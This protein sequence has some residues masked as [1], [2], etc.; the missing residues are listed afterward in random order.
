M[1][2]TNS[3]CHSFTVF[4]PNQREKTVIKIRLNDECRNGH[5]DFSLT[6]DIYEK[7]GTEV[8]RDSGGGCC[9]EHILKLR[10]DLKP[11]ADLH[12]S[13]CKGI[14][15]HAAANAFYWFAGWRGGLRTDCHGASG[16]DGKTPEKCREILADHLRASEAEMAALEA[17]GAQTQKELQ[18]VIEDLKMPERWQKE[19]DAAIATLEAWTGAKFESQATR[20]TWTPLS[21][22]DRA[23]IAERKASG[24]YLPENVAKRAQE[25]AQK[26]LDARIAEIEKEHAAKLDS[27]RDDRLVKLWL[28]RVAGGGH[29]NAIY[30]RH[31]N[32]IAFNWS[33]CERLVPKGEFDAIVASADL[34]QLPE[35]ITF[36]WQAAPKR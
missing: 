21:A 25:A 28:A 3:L 4:S 23:L 26:R 8:W 5:E 36:Q 31:T 19:A 6:A 16:R 14:P 15:M 9:H 17:C 11:L 24:Y 7:A 33:N 30:Y 12:L 18:A 34:T 1:K 2:K 29:I 13:T 27:L 10:P 22:E 20:E 35:G 32:Q